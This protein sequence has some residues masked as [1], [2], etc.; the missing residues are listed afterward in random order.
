[1][2]DHAKEIQLLD[3]AE[4]VKERFDYW[5]TL[6]TVDEITDR[7]LSLWAGLDADGDKYARNTLRTLYESKANDICNQ[8]SEAATCGEVEMLIE[9]KD[10]RKE[11]RQSKNTILRGGK[12]AQASVLTNDVNDP[13]DFYIDS[14]IFGTEG[15]SAGT[16]KFVDE[17]RTGLFGATLL[18]KNVISSI[19]TAA[20]TTAILTSVIAFTEVNGSILSEMAL[21]MKSADLY[22][23][24]TFPDLT[25]TSTMQIIFN[26][27]ISV[28]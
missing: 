23:M 4:K 9:Y 20:P 12:V 10:G 17:T 18:A 24:I 13:F 6:F 16:P 26:W 25:K 1:M 2:G 28:L 7:Q 21:K 8:K 22:S 5:R 11:I 14:M 3:H 19:D 15:S 27:R